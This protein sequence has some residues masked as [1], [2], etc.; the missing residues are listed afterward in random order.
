MCQCQSISIILAREKLTILDFQSFIIFINHNTL[1]FRYLCILSIYVFPDHILEISYKKVNPSKSSYIRQCHCRIR[2][3]YSQ[4]H[5]SEKLYYSPI[6]HHLHHTKASKQVTAFT[7]LSGKYTH[8]ITCLSSS[9]CGLLSF[10]G[11]GSLYKHKRIT[12]GKSWCLRLS[13]FI[14][15]VIKINLPGKSCLIFNFHSRHYADGHNYLS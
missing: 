5:F 15:I 11:W 8:L 14:K 3:L 7:E 2:K 6:L 4:S 12:L 1:D 10:M 9:A 13:S